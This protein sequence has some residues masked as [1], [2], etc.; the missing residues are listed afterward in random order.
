MARTNA[1]NFSGGL[2]FPYA[3]TGSDLFKKEDVQVLAQAVDQHDHTSGKGL[4]LPAS[5]IPNGFITS[6][7]IADGTITSTDI[8]DGTIATADIASNAVS[9]TYLAPGVT[10]G[11]STTS[12]A[13]VDMPDMLYTFPTTAVSSLT[14]EFTTSVIV[15]GATYA[16]FNLM[17]DGTVL[18][19]GFVQQSG[20][21]VTIALAY[22]VYNVT[23]TTH[24][25]K[26]QWYLGSAGTVTASGINRS[27]VLRAT[28]R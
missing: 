23:A 8:A 27:L 11:P 5:A 21:N 13:P 9:V 3:T 16:I 24:T 10:V 25:A 2:Q 1:T 12:T 6:A 20:V 14:L 4:V 19:T 7:M 26:V 22:A 18:I 28:Y 15:T 17:L